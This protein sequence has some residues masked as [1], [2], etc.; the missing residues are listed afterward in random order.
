LTLQP[1]PSYVPNTTGM[2]QLKIEN[3][4]IVPVQLFDAGIV[5]TLC[6]AT[7]WTPHSWGI[8]AY[9]NEDGFLLFILKSENKKFTVS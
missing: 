6:V 3:C 4:L 9:K 5:S 7:N 1:A 8:K 2:S